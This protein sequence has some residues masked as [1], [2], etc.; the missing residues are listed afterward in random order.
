MPY[1]RRSPFPYT[2]SILQIP[3]VLRKIEFFNSH[4]PLHSE[5]RIE[6]DGTGV[7]FC[8]NVEANSALIHGV[9][10]CRL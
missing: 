10:L 4:R 5:P 9:D 2:F 1:K 8:D 3:A 7:T 6:S